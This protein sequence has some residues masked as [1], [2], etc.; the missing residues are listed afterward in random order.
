MIDAAPI[1]KSAARNLE[2]FLAAHPSVRGSVL[3]YI[4]SAPSWKQTR[5]ALTHANA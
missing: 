3:G 1:V 2:E 4:A 5:D